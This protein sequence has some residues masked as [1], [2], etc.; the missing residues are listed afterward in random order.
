MVTTVASQGDARRLAARLLDARLAACVQI[1]GP[2]ES[3]YRWEGQLQTATEWRLQFKS[4][5]A[6]LAEAIALLAE[7]HPYDEPEILYHYFDGGSSSYQAWVR[8]E[9]KRLP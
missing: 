2:I 9:T 1:D 7:A 3:H 6:R 5:G 4:T 8:D